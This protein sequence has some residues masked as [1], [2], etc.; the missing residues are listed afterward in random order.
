LCTNLEETQQRVR[1]SPE[2]LE[3]VISGWSRTIKDGEK[4]DWESADWK[5]HSVAFGKIADA[6]ASLQGERTDPWKKVLENIKKGLDSFWDELTLQD[7]AAAEQLHRSIEKRIG[8]I[9]AR[10]FGIERFAQDTAERLKIQDRVA[11]NGWSR[12]V[13]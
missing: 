6:C 3:S 5:E 11:S 10:L 12:G 7:R 4:T 13:V 8:F 9:E 2:L 1:Q